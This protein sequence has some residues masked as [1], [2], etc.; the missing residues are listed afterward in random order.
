MSFVFPWLLALPPLPLLVYW[1]LPPL[2]RSSASALRIPFFDHAA[3]FDAGKA[4]RKN[5]WL[6]RVLQLVAWLALVIAAALPQQKGNP[7]AIPTEGRDLM[8]AIDLSGSMGREDFSTSQRV[9]DRLTVVC[10]VAKDFIAE[11]QGDRVGLILFGSM[12]FLQ[13]PLTSDLDS[14]G[15]MLDEAEVGLAGDSTAIGDAV[16][17]AVKV[18][19][20]RPA[21][22][23]VLVLLS[24][25][26][27]NSGVLDPQQAAQLAAEAG[28]RIHTIGVG[29]DSMKVQTIFGSKIV[30]PA[31]DL[32]EKTLAAI[33]E[34]TGGT[35]FR[36]KSPEGLAEIYRR[37]E[38][39]EPTVG[40]ASYLRPTRSLFHWPLAVAL[41]FSM[42]VVLLHLPTKSRFS[43]AEAA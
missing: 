14:V 32:D 13:T 2:P 38:E 22:E 19:R 43:V 11:R 6:R 15:A 26:A 31:E 5:R 33:A 7:I 23:R 27:N 34:A 42:L 20:E 8:L 3:G 4:P 16:G 28:I 36:A 39:L 29:A 9:V 30:N 17:M 40:D 1:L 18:L 24:D 10:E 21:Q 25:G 12:A 35:F 37:I 41:G